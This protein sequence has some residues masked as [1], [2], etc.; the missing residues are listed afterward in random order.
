MRIFTIVVM[1]Y[2]TSHAMHLSAQAGQGE[3]QGWPTT[4]WEVHCAFI[5]EESGADYFTD[6]ETDEDC[7]YTHRETGDTLTLTEIEK[8]RL[9]EDLENLSERMETVGF[10]PPA[11]DREDIWNVVL[12]P[13]DCLCED[14]NCCETES[15]S[16]WYALTE[17]DEFL[18]RSMGEEPHEGQSY[19][20]A[21][22]LFHAV[23][24]SYFPFEDPTIESFCAP[25][26]WIGEGM[27]AMFANSAVRDADPPAERKFDVSLYTDEIQPGHQTAL[28]WHTTAAIFGER[29]LPKVLEQDFSTNAGLTGHGIY[30]THKALLDMG[31]EKGF[32]NAYGS[33]AR[34]LRDDKYYENVQE[35]QLEEVES[36]YDILVEDVEPISVKAA[37]I[38]IDPRQ[39][40]DALSSNAA[41]VLKV[42]LEGGEPSL[43]LMVDGIGAYPTNK[44]DKDITDALRGDEP[45]E[46]WVQVINVNPE[47][48]HNTILEQLGELKVRIEVLECLLVPQDVTQ[49]KYLGKNKKGKPQLSMIYSLSTDAEEAGERSGKFNLDIQVYGKQDVFAKA[50]TDFV[51]SDDGV[52]I[53]GAAVSMVPQLGTTES[54]VEMDIVTNTN[55]LPHQMH[56]GMQLE[57]AEIILRSQMHNPLAGPFGMDIH[58]RLTDRHVASLESVTVPAGTFEAYRIEYNTAATVSFSGKAGVLNIMR[59]K[60]EQSA[61]GHVTLWVSEGIGWVKQI[62]DTRS[63]RNTYELVNVQR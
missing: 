27:A 46:I 50:T 16:E 19:D 25:F 37:K 9:I 1:I 56:A 36:E 15:N 62:I 33:F 44:I 29:I 10:K 18:V 61:T 7:E 3:S 11:L 20:V 17:M 35:L 22:Q 31:I 5:N 54:S 30:Q 48:P 38:K 51:C 49:M 24:G 34:H 40:R 45:I 42:E 12:Y 47:E 13:G 55:V 21:H 6:Y 39:F 32:L 53:T 2:M 26:C 59:R 43:H 4:T 63:G 8:W 41:A 52:I 57:N 14:D 23:K 58:S 28:F 60:I